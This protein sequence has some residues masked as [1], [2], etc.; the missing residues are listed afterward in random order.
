MRLANAV[1]G[2]FNGVFH[3]QYVARAVIEHTQRGIKRRRFPRSRWAS[4]EDD[5][6]GFGKAVEQQ[7]MRA[8]VHTKGVER[9]ACVVLVKDAQNHSFPATRW[10]SRNADVQLLAAK[11]QADPPV[12]RNAPFGDV[13]PRHNLDPTDHNRRD[14][15]RHPQRFAQ[16]PV[17]PHAEHQTRFKRLNVN[18][19]H[20]VAHGVC[21]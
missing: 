8:C 6:I 15:R 5:A 17:N 20:T 16:H 1:D 4:D 21:N 10:Q 18:I 12:L 2:I 9:N 14:M 19:R 11:C 7:F 13:Q 3:R